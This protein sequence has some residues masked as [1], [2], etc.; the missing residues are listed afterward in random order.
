[1]K[2]KPNLLITGASGFVGS[3]F[4]EQHSTKFEI[5]A[6]KRSS[7][8]LP[9]L[10]SDRILN[11]NE[12]STETFKA[13][14]PDTLLHLSSKSAF[15]HTSQEIPEYIEANVTLPSIVAEHFL[16]AGGRRII[17]IGSFWQHSENSP[18]LPNS[19]YAATK[20]C[21]EDILDYYVE[22]YSA[23]VTTLKLFDTYGPHDPRKKVLK[24]V[25]EAALSQQP[26]GVTSGEQLIYLT[27]VNDVVNALAYAANRGAK[28]HEKYFVRPEKPLKLKDIIITYLKVN[29]LEAKLKWGEVPHSPRDFFTE[30]DILPNLPGWKPEIELETGLRN[31]F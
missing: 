17:N 22:R 14:R 29:E 30:L 3:N 4:I 28:R 27:H 8:S 2:K 24:L 31:L 13:I 9:S 25:H 23:E 15:N 19:F 26:L 18:Y 21:F 12:V 7:T 16:L 11:F 1:M 5:F 20:Q 6:I 10:R